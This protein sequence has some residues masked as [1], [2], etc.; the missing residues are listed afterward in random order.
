MISK[1]K[2]I[3]FK[4]EY[5]LHDGSKGPVFKS[6]KELGST[7]I[8]NL[9]EEFKN[10]QSLLSFLS[11]VL[12]ANEEKGAKPIPPKLKFEILRAVRLRLYHFEQEKVKEELINSFEYWKSSIDLTDY[13]RQAFTEDLN[14]SF[15]Y[16]EAAA[17][18]L[19][20]V[21][22]P[23][24]FGDTSMEFYVLLT[25]KIL[26]GFKFTFYFPNLAAAALFWNHLSNTRY[27]HSYDMPPDIIIQRQLHKRNKS[28]QVITK[29]IDQDYCL[30]PFYCFL[31]EV[32]LPDENVPFWHLDN[33]ISVS[34]SGTNSVR[35]IKY[36]EDDSKRIW[37]GSL[38]KITENKI[39]SLKIK[40]V[41]YG[42]LFG[43]E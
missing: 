4:N 9:R 43:L 19:P 10:L 39:K 11:Q 6:Q 12:K 22:A 33:L 18:F 30:V 14:N 21:E 26:N 1:P 32:Y 41:S 17:I 20:T 28:G 8:G 37:Y 29:I 35:T 16:C 25:K 24:D 23:G 3:L 38:E 42:E 13:H 5:T 34:F 36:S 27:H 2:E 40:E 15:M 31:R 7:L